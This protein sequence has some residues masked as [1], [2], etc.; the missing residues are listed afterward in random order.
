MLRAIR[1]AGLPAPAVEAEHEGVLLLEFIPNDG[2]FS[3]A[4][5]RDIGENLRKL[6]ARLGES[7]GWPVDYRLGSVEVDN[8]PSGD[9][10]AFWGEQRL[11]SAAALLDRP[12]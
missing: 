7:F 9:W 2:L 10:P 8:R 6:H 12:W 1:G 11:V 5:W 3:P 4:A